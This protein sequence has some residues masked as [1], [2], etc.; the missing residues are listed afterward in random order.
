MSSMTSAERLRATYAFQP[1]DHLVRKEFYISPVTIERWRN[2][3]MLEGYTG[4]FSRETD[5]AKTSKM[6]ER[7]STI[8]PSHA[9]VPRFNE[10]GY[11]NV[12]E[13][14][15]KEKFNYDPL[16]SCNIKV[17]LGWVEL[18]FVPP[19]EEKVLYTQG[20]YEI[21][22]DISG[23]KLKVFKE[24]RPGMDE[25]MPTY[26]KSVVSS[27]QEWEGEV[28]PRLDPGA[29]GRY[30]EL[31]ESSSEAERL[32]D[33]NGTFVI[34][35]I[36]GAYNYLR[37]L[38]GPE[39]VLYSFYDQQDMIRDMLKCWT[40]LMDVSLE[41][42]QA[43]V[44]LDE[45]SVAED[46]CYK[47]GPLISPKMFQE[48]LAPCYSHVISRARMRQKRHLYVHVDSDGYV[49]PIVNLYMKIGFNAMSPWEVA[50]GNDIVKVGQ[51][52]PNL[53]MPAGGIDKRILAEDK[54]AIDKHL[55]YIIPS[56]LKRGGYIPT[57]DHGVPATVSWESYLYYRKRICELD[58]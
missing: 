33:R 54:Q 19:Y 31:E 10:K 2:E 1:V 37:K 16:G 53:I 18:P 15:A 51:K 42:I 44:E 25:F 8:F 45:I 27:R 17:N 35:N 39:G 50:A 57:C 12:L 13:W 9:G 38:L 46:I 23:G 28:K 24:Q 40:K 48:F 36:T 21:I 3:G 29:P 52:Y 4:N 58:H 7:F 34:Q 41:Q 11:K 32:R 6:R 55:E 30:D 26:L 22:Q 14:L 56:M 5:P 47:S 20:D 49:V 43:L